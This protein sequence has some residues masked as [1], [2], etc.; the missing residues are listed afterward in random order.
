MLTVKHS[1]ISRAE[2]RAEREKRLDIYEGLCEVAAQGR[3]AAA[4]AEMTALAKISVREMPR[5]KYIAFKQNA[6]KV[7]RQAT[8]LEPGRTRRVAQ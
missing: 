7:L 4:A 6:L 8:N 2:R 5:K 3:R 1:G